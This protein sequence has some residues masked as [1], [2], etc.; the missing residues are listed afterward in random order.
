[1][2][3]FGL[4][5]GMGQPLSMLQYAEAN[6]VYCLIEVRRDEMEI[7]NKGREVKFSRGNVLYSGGFPE[8]VE[9]LRRLAT[10]KEHITALETLQFYYD[11]FIECGCDRN[12]FFPEL[13]RRGLNYNHVR[14]GIHIADYGQRWVRDENGCLYLDIFHG[15]SDGFVLS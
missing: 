9:H 5:R 14:M 8:I 6:S 1:M 4:W 10:R 11:I 15:F 7:I 13:K 3:L 2:G 12:V